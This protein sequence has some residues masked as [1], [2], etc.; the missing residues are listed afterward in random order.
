MIGMI[1]NSLINGLM[2][3]WVRFINNVY[4]DESYLTH[5]LAQ[6]TEKQPAIK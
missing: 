5:T 2:R 6:K 4:K 1:I 3:S